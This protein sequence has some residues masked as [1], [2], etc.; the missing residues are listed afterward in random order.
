MLFLGKKFVVNLEKYGIML[1]VIGGKLWFI[2]LWLLM[3]LPVP[4]NQQ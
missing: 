3:A 1:K 2:T 4:A